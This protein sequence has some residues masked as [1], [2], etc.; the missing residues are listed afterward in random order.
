MELV[1]I[2]GA[3]GNRGWATPMKVANII[4]TIRVPIAK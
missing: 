1:G 2:L 3:Y 4:T